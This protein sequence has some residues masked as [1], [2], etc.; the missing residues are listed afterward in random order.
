MASSL[1]P[2]NAV[3]VFEAAARLQNFSRAAEELA[4]TQAGVSYQIKL[5]EERVGAPLF[6]RRGRGI[7]LTPLGKQIA[8]RISEAFGMMDAAFAS[9]REENESVLSITTSRTFA[10]NWLAGRLGAFNLLRPSLAVRLHVS[11]ELVDLASGEYDIAIRGIVA[12]DP[13]YSCRFLIRQMVTPMASPAFLDRHPLRR[14]V[15]LLGVPR[16]SHEDEWWD[17]WFS[18]FDDPE[19]CCPSGSGI[20]F[21]SQVLDGQAAIAGHGVAMIFPFMFRDAIATGQLVQ[22]FPQFAPEPREFYVVAPE[23]KRRL[24]KVRAFREWLESEVR[25]SAAGLPEEWL[26]PR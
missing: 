2:L 5:L 16:L 10:T 19:L 7:E 11:D 21:D 23:H 17:L 20:R 14:P 3:R 22:I 4:M 26:A 9:I 6:L 15:D 8:P 24:A 13:G 25:A 1:P 18:Q 12:P